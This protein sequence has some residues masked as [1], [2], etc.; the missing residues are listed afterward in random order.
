VNGIDKPEEPFWLAVR[1]VDDAQ[2][3]IRSARTCFLGDLF[4]ISPRTDRQKL[5][6]DVALVAIET[7]IL[8]SP[9]RSIRSRGYAGVVF[10]HRF[11]SGP[12]V[13]QLKTF[14]ELI[15][16]GLRYI[17]QSAQAQLETRDILNLVAGK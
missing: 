2:G 8:F 10:R 7:R 3:V 9:K 13:R 5:I 6:P 4:V 17:I 12:L 14:P 1:R 11:V 15:L 16:W